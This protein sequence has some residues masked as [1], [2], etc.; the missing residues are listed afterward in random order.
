MIDLSKITYFSNFPFLCFYSHTS[1]LFSANFI[2]FVLLSTLSSSSTSQILLSHHLF[3]SYKSPI[4]LNC[5]SFTCM[6]SKHFLPKL[7]F[8]CLSIFFYSYSYA[9]F[10]PHPF[11][12]Y[13]SQVFAFSSQLTSATN[14][15]SE[16]IST[17][18]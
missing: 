17:S 11:K 2:S 14:L 13:T 4:S 6:Y 10:C 16:R 8:Y 1:N 3:S 7:S 9:T 18:F 15:L 5:R 12:N